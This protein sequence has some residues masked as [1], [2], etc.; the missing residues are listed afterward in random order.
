VRLLLIPPAVSAAPTR[1][2]YRGP[3]S[4]PVD[5]SAAQRRASAVARPGP[6]AERAELVAL[7]EELRDA[8][9]RAPGHVADVTGLHAAAEVAAAGPVHVIDRPRWVQV[10]LQIFRH[11]VGDVLPVPTVPGA[12]RIAGEEMGLVLGFLA[13]KVLG[14][15]DPFTPRLTGEGADAAGRLVLVAPNVLNAERQMHLDPSDFRLWVC[16][17]EQTHAVQFAAAPWLPGHLSARVRELVEGI[18]QLGQ[19]ADRIQSVFEA[20]PR[21]LR[22]E[23][24]RR[25]DD[26]ASAASAHALLDVVLDEEQRAFVAEVVATMSLLE[27]HADVVMDAGGPELIKTLPKIRK[28]FEARRDGRGPLDVMLRRLLGLDAKVAQYRNGAVFVRGVVDKVGHDGLNAVWSGPEAL[29]TAAEVAD[30]AAWVR[31]VHG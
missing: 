2:G 19:D 29:P 28:R 20:L 4:T 26:D 30:P 3:V 25:A 21:I 24:A 16:L 14:Q 5:W 12:A 13:T 8:A 6:R 17:H 10:N 9:R 15:F 22:G 31:R 1:G 18:G 23:P 27:G 11:L 7:V